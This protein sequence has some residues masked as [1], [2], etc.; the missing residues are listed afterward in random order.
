MAGR[1]ATDPTIRLTRP[2]RAA[3]NGVFMKI[4]K[5]QAENIKRLVAVE[6]S[7]DGNLVEITGKNGQGKTSVLDAILW[8]LAGNKVVQ[9]RPVRD[10]ADRGHVRLDLGEYI[11]TKK[12]KVK[13]GGD[14]TI[15]L[16]VENR[17][18]AKYSSPQDLL[19]KFLGDLS[20]DPLAFSRMK[21]RDQVAALQA[22][23]PGYDFSDAANRAE[24]LRSER[25]DVN[26]RARDLEG[27]IG[28][29]IIP[30][31]EPAERVSVE[32]LVVQ[33]QQAIDHNNK[34]TESQNRATSLGREIDALTAMIASKRDEIARLK[35]EIKH[36]ELAIEELRD[37]SDWIEVEDLVDIE[38]IRAQI[39]AA[40]T[41]NAKAVRVEE[42][43]RLLEEKAE[44]EALSTALTK[45]IKDIAAASAKAV[46]N[47]NLPVEGLALTD[48]AVLLN[49]QPFD[50]AS[51]AEQLRASIAIAGA[52]NPT[53]RVIRV[54]DGS[55]LDGDSWKL[56]AD[57]AEKN[58]I[59]IW[60]E[61]VDS[62]RP[63]AVIIHDGRV[64]GAPTLEAAE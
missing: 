45:K 5:F 55:L 43:K 37:E 18:G 7:P 29:I 44:A 9:S 23:V 14:C 38:P 30:D 22:L 58:D 4:L 10:G 51:D 63:S 42:K 35:E 8:A 31:G 53:L 47:A 1:E 36:H 32:G 50:Q 41:T 17:D 25:T 13:E 6:I 62:D 11:V 54:R 15:S 57:Y 2:I 40:E 27:R 61:V 28:G 19:N 16:T 26:R 49:G 56:L 20:F 52:I 64:A 34:V 12:F 3:G 48:E 60:A 39:A 59:Q 24:K 33:L 46:A 21:P